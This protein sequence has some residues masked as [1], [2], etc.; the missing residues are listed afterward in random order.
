VPHL[1]KSVGCSNKNPF[2][3]GFL[4]GIVTINLPEFYVALAIYIASISRS[5]LIWLLEW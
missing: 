5:K 2:H 3:Q 4:T 1:N